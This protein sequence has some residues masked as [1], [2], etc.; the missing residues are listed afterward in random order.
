MFVSFFSLLVVIKCVSF[1]FWCFSGSC[2][3]TMQLNASVYSSNLDIMELLLSCISEVV[4]ESF[5]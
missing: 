4:S 3:V 2:S 5:F 1:L